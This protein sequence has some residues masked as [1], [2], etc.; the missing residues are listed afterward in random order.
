METTEIAELLGYKKHL[1]GGYQYQH[2]K[3]I[4]DIMNLIQFIQLD[5]FLMIGFHN[6]NKKM[7]LETKRLD[8][9]S[10]ALL[11]SATAKITDVDERGKSIEATTEYRWELKPGKVITPF[12]DAP[13]KRFGYIDRKI[14]EMCPQREKY[15]KRLGKAGSWFFKVNFRNRGG[16]ARLLVATLLSDALIDVNKNCPGKTV[17]TFEKARFSLLKKGIFK[18][19]EY[20][21]TEDINNLISNRDRGWLKKWLNAI[22]VIEPPTDIV[23]LYAPKKMDFFPQGAKEKIL[24]MDK[25]GEKDVLKASLQTEDS[26]S[27]IP[28]PS[29][30]ENLQKL[31]RLHT[32]AEISEMLKVS[33]SS[34][35]M[36]LNGKRKISRKLSSKIDLLKH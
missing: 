24:A 22:V 4:A 11:I 23:D 21:K 15:E 20:E 25:S 10:P 2:K 30:L 16:K 26:D 3:N 17:E 8:L 6:E 12:L 36:V 28:F 14:I 27:K 31:R 32:L 5:A 34:I 7:K 18:V 35:S 1:N 13:N 9:K 19:F 29:Q 33:K